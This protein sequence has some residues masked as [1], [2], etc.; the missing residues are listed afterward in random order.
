VKISVRLPLAAAASLALVTAVTGCNTSPGAAAVV[1]DNRISA[2]TLQHTVNRALKDPAAQQQLGQDRAGFVRSELSRLITNVI[3]ARAAAGMH[4][5]VSNSDVDHELDTLAQQTGGRQQL[6]QA[7]SASGVPEPD[8]RTF[9]RYFVMQQKLGD[10]LASDINVSDAE[11]QAAYQ[12]DIDKYD[13]VDSAHILLKTKADAD[14][15]LAQVRKNP[16][17]FAALA[18]QLSLDTGSKPNGGELGFQGHSQFVKPFADAIFAAKPGSFIEVQSQFGWHVVHVIAH[19]T[20]P[21]SEVAPQLKSAILGPKRQALVTQQLSK[22][23]KRIGVHVNPRYGRWDP[24]AD[25]VVAPS[26]KSGLSS[27]APTTS[28]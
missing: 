10:A 1:G 28:P 19:K 8:L 13:Q 4:V 6:I 20:T 15:V 23:A 25:K 18:A 27:P 11:L 21:L 12:K 22:V 17:S 24:A 9:V 3:V 14:R 7:A 2:V 26:G 16:S 5:T